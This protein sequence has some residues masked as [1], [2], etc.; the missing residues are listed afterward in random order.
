[1]IAYWIDDLRASRA[2][3]GGLAA[4]PRPDLAAMWDAA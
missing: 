1:V 2:S 4:G 3:V